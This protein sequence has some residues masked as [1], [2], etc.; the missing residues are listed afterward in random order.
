MH[1]EYSIIYFSSMEKKNKESYFALGY[2]H[3]QKSVILTSLVEIN[4]D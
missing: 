3:F 2:R 4:V 1:E